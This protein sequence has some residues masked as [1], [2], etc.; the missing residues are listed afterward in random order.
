MWGFPMVQELRLQATNAGAWVPSL[1]GEI[2][3]Y[4]PHGVAKRFFFMWYIHKMEYY[5][6][7]KRYILHG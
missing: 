5:S 2:R 7:I 6:D 1:V 3:S 4:M